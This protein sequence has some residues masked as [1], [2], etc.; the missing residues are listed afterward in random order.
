MTENPL[1]YEL[2]YD[3]ATF[4]LCLECGQKT[5]RLEDIR[6]LHC[7]QCRKFHEGSVEPQNTKSGPIR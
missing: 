2:G 1:S 5:Y 4:L 7:G 6:L 3:T